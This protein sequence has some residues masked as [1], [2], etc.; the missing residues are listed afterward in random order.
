MDVVWLP[1][2]RYLFVSEA[3]ERCD[4]LGD[5]GISAERL[6]ARAHILWAMAFYSPLF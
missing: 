5:D 2:S 1:R 3:I 4:A 6:A